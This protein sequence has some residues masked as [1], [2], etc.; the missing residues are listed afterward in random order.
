MRDY[1]AAITACEAV[2]QGIQQGPKQAL[3][4]V[5]G[6]K[7]SE[8]FG[9]P[10]I[11]IFS[12]SGFPQITGEQKSARTRLNAARLLARLRC[13]FHRRFL[14]ILSVEAKSFALGAAR[15]CAKIILASF[16]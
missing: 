9:C 1:A 7:I 3:I 5:R 2:F 11:R 15:A 8:H 13:G 6:S 10:G 14:R 4:V 12:R 16:A